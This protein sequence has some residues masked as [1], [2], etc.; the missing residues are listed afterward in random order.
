MSYYFISEQMRTAFIWV[1]FVG[2][3]ISACGFIGHV[4]K[5]N[6]SFVIP[7]LSTYER[8][9]VAKR[10]KKDII[11]SV[12]VRSKIFTFH[13]VYLLTAKGQSIVICIKNDLITE[14]LMVDIWLEVFLILLPTNLIDDHRFNSL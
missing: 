10:K 9:I 2:F 13:M 3:N 8:H 7:E 6:G 11:L 1:E 14:K 5:G 12:I 4:A